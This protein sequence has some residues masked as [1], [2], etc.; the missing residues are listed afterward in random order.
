MMK[1]IQSRFNILPL[2]KTYDDISAWF[3]TSLGR[4]LLI[5]ER[6]AVSEELRYLFG[7]H[8]MQLSSVKNANF[9]SSSR[10]NHCFSLAPAEPNSGENMHNQGVANFDELP[11]PDEFV[12]VTVLH[13]VLE[14]SENPHQVLKEAARVTIPRGYIIIV[15]FNPL[16]LAGLVHKL[17]T[18]LGGGGVSK[19]RSLRQGRMKDWLEFLDFSCVTTR[20]VF[21][22]LPIN[23]AR[24]LSS[25]QILEKLRY[26]NK[27]PGGMSF[28]MV[29]RK[30]KAGL[31]PLKPQWEKSSILNA[32]PI[33]KQAMKGKVAKEC[34]VLPF[35]E[36]IKR[37]Y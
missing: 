24:F 15:A 36:K 35:R 7:Y 33:A 2:R 5:H 1:R 12:D 6:K 19:R 11:L 20:N 26:K 28:V 16:S 30:D 8:F 37:E 3:T 25:T 31:T 34:M 10:I 27:M 29:A 32:M 9:G 13:H 23:N 18:I 4:R 22:N 17:S 21:H 14:F